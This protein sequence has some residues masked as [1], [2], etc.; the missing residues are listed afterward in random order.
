MP[1]DILA[2]VE[3]ARFLA[4][5]PTPEQIIAYHPSPEA[6]E[7]AYALVEAER[8]GTISEDERTELDSCVYLEH[9]MR[10]VKVEAHRLLQQ[11][12]S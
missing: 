1:T 11:R 3:I 4:S 10:L 6:A 7:R 5:G 8:N 9:M 2:S 12:A